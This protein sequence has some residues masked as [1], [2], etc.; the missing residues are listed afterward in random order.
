MTG[1]AKLVASS[2]DPS[3]GKGQQFDRESVKKA[4]KLEASISQRKLTTREKIILLEGSKLHG[5][6]FPSWTSPVPSDFEQLPGRP[7]FM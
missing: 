5:S 6:R 4:N 3:S 2:L 1:P 7:Y